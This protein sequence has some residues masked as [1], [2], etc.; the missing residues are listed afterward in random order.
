MFGVMLGMI[1]TVVAIMMTA[2]GATLA[3]LK[4]TAITVPED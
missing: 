1:M 2:P 3:I 4:G